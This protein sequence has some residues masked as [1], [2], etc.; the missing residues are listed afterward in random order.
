MVHYKRKPVKL[1]PLPPFLDD[2]TEIWVIEATDEIF[3]D[4]EKYLSRRDFYLQKNFTC[5]ATGH[6]GYTFFEAMESETEASREINSIFPEGLRSRVLEF[7]QF[8]NTARMDD[9]VNQV[10]EH[11]KDHFNVGDRVSVEHDNA[12][13]FGTILQMQDTSNLHNVFLGGDVPEEPYRSFTYHITLEDTGEQITR[14][15]TSE[16]ARDRRVYSK[17]VLK[18]FLRSAVSREPWNGAPWI[19]KEHLAKRYNINTKV[20]EA[21]TRDAIIAAKKEKAANAANANNANYL[22]NPPGMPHGQNGIASAP[23]GPNMQ[24]APQSGQGQATFVNFAANHQPPFRPDLGRPMVQPPMNGPPRPYQ[25]FPPAIPNTFPQMPPPAQIPRNLPPHLAQLAHQGPPSGPG[26]PISLPFQNNFMQYQALAPTNAPQQ[27]QAPPVRQ[28]EH[29]KYPIEDLR[30]KQPRLSTVRPPLKF[31][32]DDVPDGVDAPEE[33]KKT[34][35]L[36]KSVGPLLCAWETLNVHDTIYSLD[37]FTLDDF[38]GALRFSSEDTSCELLVEVHCSILKQIVND[39]GKLQVALP[40]IEQSDDSESGESLKST[41]P[42]L[43]PEPPVRTTRSSLRKSEANAI[44]V[45]PRTPTPEPPRQI[46]RASEFLAEFDWIEQCKI[47]NFQGGGWQAILVGLI[48]HLSFS[49]GQKEAC[50]EILAELVP[51]DEEPTVE[52]IANLYVYLDVNLRIAAL[53]MVLRLTVATEIFRDQLIAA[54]QEMTRLRKEKIEFQKKRKEL[55]DELF[56]LDIERKIGLPLNTPPDGQDVAMTGTEESKENEESA[57][58]S[59]EEPPTA[60]N[61]KLRHTK[62]NK[63][64]RESDKEKKEKAKKAK[65][66]AAKSKQQKE[67][68]KLLAAID[69]KKDEL[70]ECEASINELDDDLR[71]TLVHRSKVLGK[72]RFLNK[73]YWFEHNGMPYGGVPNSSTSKYGYANGRLWVQGPDEHEIQPN[74]EEPAM[75]Y[76]LQELGYTV[77]QRKEKEEGSTHLSTSTQWGYYDDPSDIDKLMAWLDERGVRE[78]V[79]RKEL[80]ASR[81]KITEYMLKMKEHLS[82]AEKSKTDEEETATRISTRTKTYVEKDITQDRCLLWTNS[83]MR[84]ELGYNHSEEYEPEPPKKVKKGTAK[85]SKGKGKR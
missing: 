74:L 13:R 58:E 33:N 4:Y 60:A 64:K 50:D 17:I 24:A 3:L 68:E 1:E 59:S 41:T 2:N 84:D 38:V 75:S 39:S 48:Y 79:L 25:N 47:R 5:E 29:V 30:I 56:K 43:E 34:G 9:L 80:Q 69:K 49:P 19:V 28:F 61:R 21:K 14:Y 73:Y 46:H 76:D 67:W 72:D 65:A 20:P 37:S 32:S 78:K 85:T 6:Q 23:N 44:V 57:S 36:M 10:F 71:E 70:K 83:I 82:E 62:Q 42:E 18:H 45:K 12:R 40:K 26:L 35:I 66:E 55:A 81:D 54:S 52:S 11:F 53:E 51:P 15:K 7:V 16:L 27:H 63:R 8:E 31:F 77:P 22:A